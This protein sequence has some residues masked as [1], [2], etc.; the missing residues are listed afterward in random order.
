VE[1]SVTFSYACGVVCDNA[2]T[3]KVMD[4]NYDAEDI[5]YDIQDD[6]EANKNP[7][8]TKEL[9]KASDRAKAVYNKFNDIID[10]YKFTQEE[11]NEVFEEL[12]PDVLISRRV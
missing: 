4:N 11:K 1:K 6:I 9:Q 5:C 8:R 2:G 10:S 7:F 3:A 12:D